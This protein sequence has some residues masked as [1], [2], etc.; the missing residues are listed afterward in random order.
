MALSWKLTAGSKESP[1]KGWAPLNHSNPAWSGLEKLPMYL[2]L[3]ILFT[4][5]FME[6]PCFFWSVCFRVRP[7]SPFQSS[8]ALTKLIPWAALFCVGAPLL[9]LE[10]FTRPFDV[11]H[12]SWTLLMLDKKTIAVRPFAATLIPEPQAF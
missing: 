6:F 7:G 2:M 11:L 3:C 1:H 9:Q 4:V 12:R 8:I 10:Y 5:G